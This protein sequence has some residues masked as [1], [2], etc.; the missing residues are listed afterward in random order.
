VLPA[1]S[2]GLFITGFQLPSPAQHRFQ[3]QFGADDFQQADVQ[4]S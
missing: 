2:F 1:F 3:Q 4:I